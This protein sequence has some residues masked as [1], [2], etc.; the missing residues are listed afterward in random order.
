[1][2]LLPN[3]RFNITSTAAG[4]Q[5]ESFRQ[6]RV[7]SLNYLG[8]YR[9]LFTTSRR[10][11]RRGRYGA[12]IGLKATSHNGPFR[13]ALE[14]TGAVRP[15]GHERGLAANEISRPQPAIFHP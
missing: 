15:A 14:A 9:S 13:R 5:L 6:S 4:G 3:R 11:H 8:L 1:M 12:G 7:Y 10:F 2:S